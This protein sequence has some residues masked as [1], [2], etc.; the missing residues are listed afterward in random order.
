MFHLIYPYRCP[1][2]DE[3]VAEPDFCK[4]CRPQVTP[5][6]EP[7]CLKCGKLIFDEASEYCADCREKSHYFEAGRA[8]YVYSGALKMSMYR[9]KYSNRRSYA[10]VYARH[11]MRVQRD[12]LREID[13]DGIVPVPMYEPKRRE[14]GYNQAEVFAKALSVELGVPCFPKLVVRT[15]KTPP[16]KTMSRAARVQNLIDAF[17]YVDSGVKLNR[18]LLVDDI[19]TTGSTVDAVTKVLLR[20][21]VKEVYVLCTCIGRGQ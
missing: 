4:K 20:G 10:K 1:G 16:M 21:G 5:V 6:T 3:V 9:F 8:V 15:K 13:V 12:W 2:C 11:A 18:I 19:Y 17:Q 7:Y 14:R